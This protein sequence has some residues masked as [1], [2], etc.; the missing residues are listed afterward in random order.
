MAYSN[1]YNWKFRATLRRI[2]AI[3][4]QG[5]K[6]CFIEYNEQVNKAAKDF[7]AMS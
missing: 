7:R 6:S 2:D 1:I 5:H 3:K 4:L